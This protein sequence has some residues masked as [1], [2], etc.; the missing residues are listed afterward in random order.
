MSEVFTV[1][2]M[3]SVLDSSPPRQYS[4]GRRLV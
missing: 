4:G 3:D 1:T 2:G